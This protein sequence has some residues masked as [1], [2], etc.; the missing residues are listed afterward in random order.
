MSSEIVQFVWDL[1]KNDNED[2]DEKTEEIQSRLELEENP[3]KSAVEIIKTDPLFPEWVLRIAMGIVNQD[4]QSKMLVYNL[5]FKPEDAYI[6]TAGKVK[7]RS[8]AMTV[9]ISTPTQEPGWIS[10]VQRALREIIQTEPND[11]SG[12]RLRLHAIQLAGQSQYQV[13]D[14]SHRLR[15]RL[16]RNKS[17]RDFGSLSHQYIA[18]LEKISFSR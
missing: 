3:G 10:L 16:Y 7:V 5:A 11:M 4:I 14:A 12:N 17:I 15:K 6:P 1:V 13:T 2:K 8:A 18:T 9:L